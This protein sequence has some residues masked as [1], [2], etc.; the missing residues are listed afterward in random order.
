MKGLKGQVLRCCAGGVVFCLPAH[1]GLVLEILGSKFRASKTGLLILFSCH[2]WV[3]QYIDLHSTSLYSTSSNPKPCLYLNQAVTMAKKIQK[4][5]DQWAKLL[6]EAGVILG[7]KLNSEF[8]DHLD[9][10]M[11]RGRVYMSAS[12]G[13]NLYRRKPVI[14]T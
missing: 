11:E 14:Y 5:V 10:G 3:L 7:C 6:A 12:C 8:L 4:E 1:T 9:L 2:F 13:M